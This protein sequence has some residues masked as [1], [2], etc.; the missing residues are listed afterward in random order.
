MKRGSEI[1]WCDSF[2][3]S[4]TYSLNIRMNPLAKY[5]LGEDPSGVRDE[6]M[7]IPSDRVTRGAERGG[8][9]QLRK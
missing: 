2:I 8:G 4:F 5:S 1:R 7:P 6:H 9:E 3:H